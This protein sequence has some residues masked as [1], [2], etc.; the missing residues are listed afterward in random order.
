MFPDI[1]NRKGDLQT[2]CHIFVHPDG[3]RFDLIGTVHIGERSYWREL[4]DILGVAACNSEIHYEMVRN[5]SGLPKD[6]E[7]HPYRVVAKMTGLQMQKDGIDYR[8][9]WINSDMSFEEVLKAARNPE[10]MRRYLKR[11]DDSVKDLRASADDAPEALARMLRWGIRWA[12]PATELLPVV[13]DVHRTINHRRTD[14]A[15]QRMLERDRHI[16]ALWGAGHLRRMRK[17]LKRNGFR[18]VSTYWL[19]AVNKKFAKLTTE[20]ND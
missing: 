6:P 2:A 11:H 18:L 14:Y 20:K 7:A 8:P 19:T 15:M 3:R 5:V 1:R 12:I 13:G 9:D 4:Q 10:K 16:T 17:I